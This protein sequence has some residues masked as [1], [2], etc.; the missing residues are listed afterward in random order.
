M[1]TPEVIYDMP[2]EVYHARPEIS[3]SMIK[4][5]VSDPWYYWAKYVEKHPFLQREEKSTKAFEIGSRLDDLMSLDQDEYLRKYHPEPE[6]P[7]YV[8]APKL[9]LTPSGKLTT[10]KDMVE[11][12]VLA[13]GSQ[14]VWTPEQE[15]KHLARV[16]A[17][18]ERQAEDDSYYRFLRDRLLAV[19][20]AQAIEK[21]IEHRQ[22]VI[23][24][25]DE[26]LGPMRAR[27]DDLGSYGGRPLISDTKT[28][29]A[30]LDRFATEALKYG[31]DIQHVIY[32]DAV[33][34]LTGESPPFLFRVVQ[35]RK[36][37]QAD[38][39]ELDD[40]I[41]AR[42]RRNIQKAKDH[43]KYIQDN[44]EPEMSTRRRTAELPAWA[45]YE[46]DE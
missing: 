3:R 24:W 13:Y 31:Y 39:I 1:G 42:A 22:P 21:L 44:G 34:A 7:D 2:E 28:T 38:V 43:I 16:K 23:L 26:V 20:Q 8:V 37:F 36:P 40:S 45:F 9:F 18:G 30:P 33:K 11:K 25:E 12:M 14:E 27:L 6:T 29:S 5:A 41:I 15:K 19:P 10:K 4:D 46:E 17:I 35:T 32:Q